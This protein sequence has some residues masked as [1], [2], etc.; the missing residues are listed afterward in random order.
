M[1]NLKASTGP[2]KL[3]LLTDE[4]THVAGNNYDRTHHE[5]QESDEIHKRTDIGRPREKYKSEI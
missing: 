5:Q 3:V 4:S 2:L 1:L